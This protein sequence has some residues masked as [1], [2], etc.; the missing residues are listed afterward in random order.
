[1][2][3]SIGDARIFATAFGSPTAPA[4]LAIGGW[5]GS[6][7]LWLEPFSR[8]SQNWH[9]IAYDHRGAGLTSAPLES[10]THERLVDDVFAVLDAYGVDNCVLAAESAGA[11]TA[12]SAALKQPGR[13]RGLVIVDGAYDSANSRADSPFAQGLR[14]NYA[15][16]L[17][18]FVEACVPEAD[19]EH[20]KHWGRQVLNR[21]SADAAL[22]LYLLPDGVDIRPNLGRIT[23]PVLVLHGENDKIAPLSKS[24]QLVAAVPNAMLQVI[25]GAG[26]VPTMT[27]PDVI[28]RAI[29]DHF[30]A[31]TP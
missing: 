6:W 26:H 2:F 12:L 22:A 20:I 16:T 23:Q 7:E 28:A 18:A 27:Y 10:I 3:I 15:A 25:P 24:Q 11:L 21:A 4:L 17:N 29:D 30:P 14:S 13:I 31:P 5:I 9:A 8:L 19:C 1:M